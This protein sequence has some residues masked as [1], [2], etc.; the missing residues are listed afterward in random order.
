MRVMNLNGSTRIACGDGSWL[1]YWEKGSGQK[2]FL[3]SVKE[4]INTPFSGGL[5]Q[6][7]NRLDRSWYVVPLCKDCGKKT[8]ADLEIW[9]MATL[10][11]AFDARTPRAVP[12]P[13][14]VFH[15]RAA[16]SAS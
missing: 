5:V 13:S 8:L 6:E 12:Q 16:G 7:D 11:C 14:G 2:A 1:A 4:C 15:A 10:V 3:C 9:D